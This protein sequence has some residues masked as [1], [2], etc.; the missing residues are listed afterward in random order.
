[1]EMFAKQASLLFIPFRQVSNLTDDDGNFLSNFRWFLSKNSP[2]Y[3]LNFHQQI[4]KNIQDCK[5]SMNTGRPMDALEQITI[6]P[7]SVT[8][9]CDGQSEK[10]DEDHMYESLILDLEDAFVPT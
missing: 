5:N 4:L 7:T 3:L 6:K 1:M 8:E 2:R 9:Q 10:E